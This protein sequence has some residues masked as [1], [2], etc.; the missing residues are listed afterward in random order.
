MALVKINATGTTANQFSIGKKGAT[1]FQGAT[2][3]LEALGTSGDLYIRTGLTPRLFQKYGNRWGSIALD[4]GIRAESVEEGGSIVVGDLTSYV[5]I[6]TTTVD[7]LLLTVDNDEYA[8]EQSGTETV[9]VLPD[10]PEGAAVTIKDE[11]GTASTVPLL[12]DGSVRHI[13]G[14]SQILLA[15]S[16]A[17]IHLVYTNNAWW[18]TTRS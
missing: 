7:T 6:R 12:I 17:T 10:A 14:Q 13:D 9:I 1:I 3:P 18:I 8:L 11:Q 2:T 5:A 15:E 4:P 16:Y